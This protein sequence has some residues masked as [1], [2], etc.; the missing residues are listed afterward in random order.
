MLPPE[1]LGKNR[2][3]NCRPIKTAARTGREEPSQPHEGIQGRL[4][5]G[6]DGNHWGKSNLGRS[7]WQ[8]HQDDG[9]LAAMGKSQGIRHL[10]PERE[11]AFPRLVRPNYEVT[12]DETTGYNGSAASIATGSRTPSRP[13]TLWPRTGSSGKPTTSWTKSSWRLPAS[14]RF[15]HSQAP[16]SRIAGSGRV[17]RPSDLW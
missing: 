9:G 7:R 15:P 11:A 16:L 1:I 17:D 2:R 4:V 8:H 14:M 6:L 10:S 13:I 5:L 3:A 12:S